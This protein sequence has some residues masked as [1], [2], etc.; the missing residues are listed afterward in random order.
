VAHYLIMLQEAYLVA[1]LEKF[2]TRAQRRRSLPRKLVA[3]NNAL[4]SAM[5]PDGAPDPVK[6]TQRF[7]SWVENGWVAL[8]VNQGQRV[9]RE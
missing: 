4:L 9:T 6:E 1:P 3:L 2:A 7:G 5:H 8:A